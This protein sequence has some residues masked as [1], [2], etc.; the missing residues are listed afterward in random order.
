MGKIAK[1]E[2]PFEKQP[3]QQMLF[4]IVLSGIQLRCFKK[5]VVQVS[6]DA[7]SI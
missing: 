3:K 6:V 2:N 4:E 5:S 1:V 7:I